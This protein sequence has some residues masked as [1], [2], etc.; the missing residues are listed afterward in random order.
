VL[1]RLLGEGLFLRN[2]SV[3]IKYFGGF[4]TGGPSLSP[5][6][7]NSCS[8]LWSSAL[9]RRRFAKLLRVTWP[10]MSF[11]SALDRPGLPVVV[12][13]TKSVVLMI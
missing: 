12:R 5:V 10:R 9:R 1:I 13:K 2:F 4:K 6:W 8:A 11:A 7:H 3:P